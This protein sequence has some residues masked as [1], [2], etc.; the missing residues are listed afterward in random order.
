MS[1]RKIILRRALIAGLII[2]SP[3]TLC[4]TA[5]GMAPGNAGTPAKYLDVTTIEG[6]NLAGVQLQYCDQSYIPGTGS[7]FG[8]FTC[9][10]L[11]YLN[12]G[13]PTN[14]QIV[15][16]FQPRLPS[17]PNNPL[18]GAAVP[19]SQPTITAQFNSNG[20]LA[21]NVGQ[22]TVYP[23]PENPYGKETLSF[24]S[25]NNQGNQLTLL[26]TDTILVYP[27]TTAKIFNALAS[28]DN[29]PPQPSPCPTP[30][31]S[32]SPYPNPSPYS[33]PTPTSVTPFT[34]DTARLVVEIDC[35]FPGGQTWVVTAPGA[36]ANPTAT[37][38]ANAQEVSSS[39]QT[40]PTTDMVLKRNVFIEA[41]TGTDTTGA[42]LFAPTSTTAGTPY[43][44]WVLQSRRPYNQIGSTTTYQQNL[45][46]ASFS[47]VQSSFKVRTQVGKVTP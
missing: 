26:E 12:T 16:T 4:K 25:L 9:T 32:P 14:F 22:V 40:A 5:F 23:H 38:P 20:R 18:Y 31:A 19:V 43:T 27:Q 42:A 33:L 45:A 28:A 21:N 41:G 13:D 37:P 8:P 11:M 7:P 24:W 47:V 34:G 36:A 3:G 39:R 30:L 29:P 44:I 10:A 6:N 2:I 1:C 35:A 46:V 17:L 15:R